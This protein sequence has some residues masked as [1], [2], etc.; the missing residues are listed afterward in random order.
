[1]KSN[2][3][4]NMLQKQIINDLVE[5]ID[6]HLEDPLNI[7]IIAEKAGYSKWHL[8]RMFKDMTNK[9]LA[10][11]IRYRRLTCAAIDLLSSDYSVTDLA[12]KYQFDSLPSFIRAFKRYFNLTPTQYR[13]QNR[14]NLLKHGSTHLN[15]SNGRTACKSAIKFAVI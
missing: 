12:L 10:S 2:Q 7:N 15:Y 5:W 4:D 13:L 1:M 3:G 8:Q 14:N 11:Y 9:N 6:M